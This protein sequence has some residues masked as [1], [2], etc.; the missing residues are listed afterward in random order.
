MDPMSESIYSHNSVPILSYGTHTVIAAART[1]RARD[2]V[3]GASAW[4]RNA[5]KTPMP[6][7]QAAMRRQVKQKVGSR[8]HSAR[9]ATMVSAKGFMAMSQTAMPPVY[10]AR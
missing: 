7:Q 8:R 2:F 9:I 3:A 6:T 10:E 1:T 5:T 4:A